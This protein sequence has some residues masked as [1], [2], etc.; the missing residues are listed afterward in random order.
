MP[1][2]RCQTVQGRPGSDLL[3]EGKTFANCTPVNGSADDAGLV[4]DC[5]GRWSDIDRHTGKVQRFHH[6]AQFLSGRDIG[7]VELF[8]ADVLEVKQC[9]PPWEQ[10]AKNH[11]FAET[12]GYAKPDAA[13]QHVDCTLHLFLIDHAL[14]ADPV[15]QYHPVDRFKPGLGP[16]LPRVPDH[17]RI[18]RWPEDRIPLRVDSG[19][20]VEIDKAVI[21]RRDQRVG[22]RVG[23]L[24]EPGM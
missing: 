7:Y 4:G 22:Q 20:Q 23:H 2:A 9:Q 3:S 24:A 8:D 1:D 6:V 17:F 14:R 12:R 5:T 18:D 11:P 16:Q 21:Q 19:E 13:G 10:F 15:A